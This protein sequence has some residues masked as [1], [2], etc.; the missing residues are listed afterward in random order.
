MQEKDTQKRKVFKGIMGLFRRNGEI[1][2]AAATEAHTEETVDEIETEEISDTLPHRGRMR[3]LDRVIITTAKITGEF[4]VTEEVCEGHEIE[5][6]KP[7]LKGSDL[8][9]MAAQ[10]VGIWASRHSAFQGKRAAVRRYGEAKFQGFIG[11]GDIV[12]VSTHANNLAGEVTIKPR[13]E[14][15]I[16]TGN[17]F[18]FRVGGIQKAHIGFVELIV[19]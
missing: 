17:D 11:A 4:E 19:F 15:I 5:E 13:L 12:I 3:L 18:S 2:Q 7:V 14:K 1:I 8:Y 9:D 16:I 6:G 10:L